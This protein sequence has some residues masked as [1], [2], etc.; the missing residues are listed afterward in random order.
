MTANIVCRNIWELWMLIKEC[1]NEDI[2]A[3]L[4]K[5]RKEIIIQ[6]QMKG[7]RILY[8][9][10]EMHFKG[11]FFFMGNKVLISNTLT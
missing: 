2:L 11:C 4:Y 9:D 10:R 6:L 1:G 5:H 8:T 7:K 3:S